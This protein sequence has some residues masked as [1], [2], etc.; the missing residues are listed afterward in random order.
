MI[1]WCV[2]RPDCDHCQLETQTLFSLQEDIQPLNYTRGLW[3]GVSA[4]QTHAIQTHT[5]VIP[6]SHVLRPSSSV[7]W[8]ISLQRHTPLFVLPLFTSCW[9]VGY[10]WVDSRGV[11]S[12]RMTW[13][14]VMILMTFLDR[15]IKDF[16]LNSDFNITDLRL[17]LDLSLLTWYFTA[18]KK[19]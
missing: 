3:K 9:Y 13:T 1:T 11:D 7:W 17:H 14:R 6:V 12:S 5:K 2:K 15:V 19:A 18:K 4:C 16:E 10:F 8:C